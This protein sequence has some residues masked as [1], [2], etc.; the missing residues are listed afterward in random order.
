VLLVVARPGSGERAVLT[1][2]QL[3][4]GVG[5]VGD[6]WAIRPSRQ[7]ADGGPHPGMQLTLMNARMTE[8]VAGA[9]DRWPLAGDQLYVDLD[10]S[11]ANLPAG[12]RLAVGDGGAVLELTAEPHTGCA[13]FTARFGLAATRLV[14]S[15]EGRA[16]RLRGA[17][18]RVVAAGPVR[19][20]DVLRKL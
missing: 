14:G 4:P 11:E 18:A 5:L 19:P 1:E 7:T 16:L 13:K 17:N 8:L 2:A 10:L 20:G 3:D 15:R 9:R 6:T 12:T